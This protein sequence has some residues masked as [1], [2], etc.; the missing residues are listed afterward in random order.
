MNMKVTTTITVERR[1]FTHYSRQ[2][3][4]GS[5]YCE[6]QYQ[7]QFLVKRWKL[8]RLTIWKATLDSEDVPAHAWI[9]AGALGF[10]SW[11]SKFAA[12]IP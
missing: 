8:G 6:D 12:Y 1:V 11:R 9:D 10:T 4:R 5:G 3:P 2:N 7:R